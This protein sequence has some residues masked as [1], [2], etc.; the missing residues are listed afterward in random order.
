MLAA[1]VSREILDNV[2]EALNALPENQRKG[3]V[4]AKV[5]R[6]FKEQDDDL[7]KKMAERGLVRWA[8]HL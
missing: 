1:P 4:V 6:H 3:P 7:Q 5:V 2:A 8:P